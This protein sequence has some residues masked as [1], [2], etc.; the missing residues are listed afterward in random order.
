M[1]ARELLKKYLPTSLVHLIY[2]VKYSSRRLR[3]LKQIEN[4]LKGKKGLEIGGPSVFFGYVVPVYKII[5]K[6][7]GINFDKK[8]LWNETPE[9]ED[10]FS[11]YRNR[12]CNQ[13]IEEGT[14]LNCIKTNAIPA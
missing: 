10:N 1:H 7:D 6:L 4:A 5:K 9:G 8:T 11:Y 12:K 13:Y 3:H 14:D 2:L